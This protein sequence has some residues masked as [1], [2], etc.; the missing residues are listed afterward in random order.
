MSACKCNG[1]GDALPV[2]LSMFEQLFGAQPG[3]SAISAIVGQ[4]A[5][6]ISVFN[7]TAKYTAPESVR[8]SYQMRN[9]G[10]DAWINTPGILGTTRVPVYWKGGIEYVWAEKQFVP[11]REIAAPTPISSETGIYALPLVPVNRYTPTA[12]EIRAA[13]VRTTGKTVDFWGTQIP[14]F[15]K[16]G[17]NVVFH[18]G[19]FRPVASVGQPI[20]TTTNAAQMNT[21]AP[22]AYQNRLGAPNYVPNTT[23]VTAVTYGVSGFAGFLEDLF[24]GI[25]NPTQANTTGG[26]ALGGTLGNILINVA[27]ARAGQA[28]M[29]ASGAR[30]TGR[31]ISTPTGTIPIYTLNGQDVVFNGQSFIPASQAVR[32][33]QQQASSDALNTFKDWILPFGLAA[34]GLYIVLRQKH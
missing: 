18:N 14:L 24:G 29:S 11:L 19:K 30:E 21:F 25:T 17:V 7:L 13:Q 15:N 4:N 23:P 32:T 27:Q 8:A 3:T 22:L 1:L 12:E 28:V 34:V 33:A 20:P 26:G 31:V 2:N 10:K 9:T 5:T 16:N 6:G